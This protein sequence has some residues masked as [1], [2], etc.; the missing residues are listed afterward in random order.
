MMMEN[1]RFIDLCAGIGGLRIPFDEI[2]GRCVLTA[3][4]D[5]YAR[6]TYLKNFVDQEVTMVGDLT[7]LDPY[8]VPEFDLLVAGFPCQPF[9]HAGKRLGFEDT[10]G[11]VFFSMASILAAQ[12][13]LP[14]VVLL[15]N[16]R[17]LRNHDSGNTLRRI[18]ETLGELGYVTHTSVLNARDFGLPQ[19]RQ[20][21][22]IVGIN[23][24]IPG[25]DSFEFP[26][27]T[28]DR[29]ALS[30]SSILESEP[31][32]ELQISERLWQGHQRRKRE[33]TMNG[34]GFGF[35]LVTPDSKYTATLSARYFKDGSEILISDCFE[36]PRLL[37][38]REAAR[39]QGFPE[40][41]VFH[42]SKKQAYKQFGNAVPV[43]VV[44]ALAATLK[45]YLG[46][47]VRGNFG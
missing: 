20:R 18:L 2:G 24:D 44:R 46:W 10:R 3:E 15:E 27:P 41:F 21:L 30:V 39:L 26:T 13:S 31:S 6:E 45:P 14:K 28:H 35:Q 38:K 5:S 8:S 12:R 25:A 23:S 47:E 32:S 42:S 36:R 43:N 34:K 19:N 7:A 9:S 22:F 17:G 1:F 29:N 16:V 11:T 40:D 37:S 33:N 4:I